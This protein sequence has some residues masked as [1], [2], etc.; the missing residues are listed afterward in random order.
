MDFT[1][2]DIAA[3]RQ[4]LFGRAR[5]QHAAGH[6][7]FRV[8]PI[9][10]AW[11]LPGKVPSYKTAVANVAYI[12]RDSDPADRFGPMP[13]AFAERRYELRAAGLI[14]PG[15]APQWA[16]RDYTIW[17]EADA[18]VAATGNPAMVS[19]WHLILEVPLGVPTGRWNTLVTEFI[20]REI[21]TRGRCTAWAIHALEGADGWIETPHCHL[22]VTALGWR[23]DA[24]QGRRA[25][26][27]LGSWRGQRALEL[28]WRRACSQA[29]AWPFK[30]ASQL[31]GGTQMA[32]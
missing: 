28:A 22:V 25:L 15:S 29:Q 9:S 32:A 20:D 6:P 30:R 19:A 10:E 7:E 12:W 4:K 24:R 8:R 2:Q 13:R 21:A 1:Q 18:A 14:L 23:H 5:D 27:G 16:A 31:W 11:N 3:M 17:E 26:G